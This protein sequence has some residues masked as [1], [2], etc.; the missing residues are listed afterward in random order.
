M[1]GGVPEDNNSSI[2]I[3]KENGFKSLHC[4][5]RMCYWKSIIKENPKGIYGIDGPDQ[6]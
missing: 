5:L 2:K 3:F 6:R 1:W 4:S